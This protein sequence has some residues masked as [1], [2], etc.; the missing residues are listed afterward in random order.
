MTFG[1]LALTASLSAAAVQ[2]ADAAGDWLDRAAQVA[3]RVPDEPTRNWQCFSATNVSIWRVGVAV[4]RGD[5]GRAI[6]GLADGVNLGLLE[7]RASR[8]AGF[9]PMS[10]A[11]WRGSP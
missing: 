4:E 11:G 3:S 7:P 9:S 6:L 2:R 1:M 10:A 8:R 5:T